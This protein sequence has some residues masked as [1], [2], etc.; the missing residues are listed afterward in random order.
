MSRPSEHPLYQLTL[1]KVREFLREPEALFW[2]FVFPI[3]LALI[4]GLA[5]RSSPE[6]ELL[7]GVAEGARAQWVL[8][9][10]NADPT[11]EAEIFSEEAARQEL[12]TGRIALVVLP[13]ESWVYWFDPTRP[14]SRVAKLTVDEVLQTAAGRTDAKPTSIREMTEK[15]S[16]YIDFLIPGLLGMNLL[17]TGVW[18]VGFYIVSARMNDLLKRLI[19]APMKKSHFLGAQILGRL[20]FLVPEVAALLAVAYWLL[21]VPIRGSLATLTLVIFVGAMTFCGF[22]LLTGSRAK[23]IEGA[24]GIMNFIMLPMWILSGIFFSTARFPDIMQPL[25]Q[26]LPLTA[27]IDAMRAVM[28]EGAT[29]AAVSGE[30]AIVAAWGVATFIGALVI[31]KWT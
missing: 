2:V 27:T 5:F 15:G 13:G 10:L 25:V 26:S 4:L 20:M 30:L 21:D 19:A 22:G 14:E 17:S 9:S 18:G 31:F 24:S 29:L 7:V 11:I 6:E 28:L 3:I 1:V 16:R 12:R 23:T 8:E